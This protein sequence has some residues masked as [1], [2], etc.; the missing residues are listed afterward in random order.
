GALH[1]AGVADRWLAA[2]RAVEPGR[3]AVEQLLDDEIAVDRVRRRPAHPHVVPRLEG[4][5]K[6]EKHVLDRVGPDDADVGP[7]FYPVDDMRRD[8]PRDLDLA[9]EQRRDAL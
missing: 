9:I 7:I 6:A 2:D 1:A 4:V 8:Q 5:V 3:I